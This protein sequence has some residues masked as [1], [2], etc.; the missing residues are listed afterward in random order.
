MKFNKLI[1]TILENNNNNSSTGIVTK[2]VAIWSRDYWYVIINGTETKKK[3][4]SFL[5]REDEPPN[6][7]PEWWCK[8]IWNKSETVTFDQGIKILKGYYESIEREDL[9]DTQL[10]IIKKLSPQ[11]KEIWNKALESSIDEWSM[12]SEVLHQLKDSV[13]DIGT[14]KLWNVDNDIEWSWSDAREDNMLGL[15]VAISEQDV[16]NNAYKDSGLIDMID[17]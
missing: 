5:S 7:T 1:N 2:G 17:F 13:G 9:N 12:I 15:S 8:D 14:W 6:F 16:V 11:D 3:L 10:E 4:R